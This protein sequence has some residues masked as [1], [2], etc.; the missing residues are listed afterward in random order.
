ME[1]G[2]EA[3]RWVVG[4][5]L[6]PASGGVLEAWAA[7]SELGPNIRDLRMELLYAQGM[8][9]NARSH[10]YGHGPEIKNPALGELLQELRDLAYRADDVMDELD[11]FRIQDEL[12]G[13][14]HAADE[15]AGGCLRNYA[16]NARHTARAI[17]SML[18]F[19]KCSRGSAGHDEPD[20]EDTRGRGIS[21]GV[22]PCLGPKT[23]VDDNEQEEDASLKVRC[24]AV[25]PCGRASST[26][27]P[28]N[29]QGDQ[30][31]VQSSDEGGNGC[32]GRLATGASDTINTVGKHLPCFSVSPVQNDANPNTASSGRRFLCCARPNKAPRREC[33]GQTPKLKFDRV[34]MS[35]TMKEIV[36]QLKP[37]CAKVSAILNLEFLAANS[38]TAQRMATSR[39]IT[40]SQSI[41]PELYGRKKETSNI[42]H[43]ITK[44]E[45]CDKDLTVLPIV[46]PGG[47]GK[48]TLMQY[49]YSDEKLQNHFEVKLW[50]CVSVNFNV[51]RLTQEVADKLPKDEKNSGDKKIEE[52]LK[53]KR[54]L[55]VLDDMW[56]CRDEDEWKKFLVP[57]TKG[58]KGSVILVTTR[59]PAIAQMVKTTDRWK[60][61]EGLDRESFE[62]LFIACAFGDNQSR[63][64]HR[65]LIET[66]DKILGKLKGSPLAAKTVGRLLRNHLDLGHWTR[67]L[68]SKEWELQH[69][70]HD[71]MPALKLS[72]DYLPFHLQQ[73]FTYCALFPEDYK[74]GA[75]ELIH[76]WIGL[77]VLHSRG[78]NKSIED[79][80]LRYLIELVNHG[81]FKKEE[82]EY[83]RTYYII[84]DL[85]HD[86][87]MKVSA[88]EC[89][90][91]C[92]SDNVRSLQIPQSIRHL[93]INMDESSVKDRK[94]FDICNICKEDFSVLGKKLKFEN[95]HSLMLFGEDQG[96]FVKTFRG[97][98][99]KA[100]AIR[101]IF[102][103]GGNYSVEDLLHNFSNLVH[104]RYLRIAGSQTPKDISR[105]YHLRVVDIKKCRSSYDLPRHMGNL[106]KLRHFLVPD[107]EMHAS[108]F[109]VGRLKSL[110]ELR[111]F[112]VRKESKGFELMQMGHLLELCGSLRIDSLEN[113]EGREEADE[114]KLMHKKHLHELMLNWNFERANE[115]P[116]R[117]EQV[118]QGLKPH[119]ILLKLSIRGHGGATCPSWLG[120]NLSVENLESLCLDG[121]AWKM[122]PPI[123]EFQL[124]NGAAEEISSNI[125]GQHFKNLKR[126]ELANLARLQRWVVGSSGQLL[127]H[128]EELIIRDCP[129]LVELP[130]SNSTCIEQEQK[131]T[132]PRLQKLAIYSCPKLVSLPPVP[133]TSSLRSVHIYRVGLD[134][135]S[136][137]Y[138]KDQREGKGPMLYIEGKGRAQD[139]TASFWTVLGFDKLTGLESLVISRNCPL[140]PLDVLQ[141]L[142]SSIKFLNLIECNM[143][144]GK[145]LGQMLS[146]MP[147]LSELYISG[148]EKIT[149]LGV[150]EQLEEGKEEIATDELLLL[151][152][153][154]QRLQILECPELSLRPD[155]G[156]LQGLAFLVSLC[157]HQCPKF[158][159]SYLP[160][161]SSSC[162][163]FP[164]SLQYLN[165]SRMETLAPLSNLASLTKLSIEGC[166]DFGGVDLG[167][168]LAN[169]CLRELSVY[170]TPNI[171]F[172]TEC[173]EEPL[174]LEMLQLQSLRTDDVA[175]VLA[176]PIC[177]LFSSSL[178]SLSI[179]MGDMERFT[180]EQDEALQ[181]LTSLKRLQLYCR[182]LQCLPAGLQKL[183]NLETLVIPGT[184]GI[185][186]SLHRGSL[187]DSLQELLITGGGFQSLPK[188]SL[189][190]SLRKLSIY[191]CSAIRSLPKES[192]PNSLQELEI[193]SCPAIRALPKGGLPS[194]LQILDVRD[195][196][197]EDLRRQCRK[198][199]GTVPV[200]RA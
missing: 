129:E 18:G 180:K 199:I 81:F 134:F 187:P 83:G 55:L 32:I 19:S 138:G 118:L 137:N 131:T 117:E 26:S 10:G 16:L 22:C 144:S 197:S 116:G 75:A 61:L 157:V 95:L 39:P 8:L 4:R 168:L 14:Y 98:F 107:D 40:T 143:L 105:F 166:G 97:L 20:E 122:F 59:F 15:H 128:L 123:G 172:S 161:P 183:A 46:G 106:L 69:G 185:I 153:Q 150:V 5:A 165:L 90:S 194:S 198:L 23:H 12:D 86:L 110:Q 80:G 53:S 191:N 170:E 47:I 6:V 92:S 119:S 155:S 49:I 133:W 77:D 196:N 79:I 76:L 163:P 182:K 192:L 193:D 82:D 42:I 71:I 162:F 28:T 65:E 195:G 37:L 63:N 3:A 108:I 38:S 160:W 103:S 115:D 27:S 145:E 188:D 177:R 156:G 141:K 11:Y 30:E 96:S 48:T 112:E 24:G 58:Q 50:V 1:V 130:F 67:V 9:N 29:Q 146:C 178:T 181:F 148:C 158:L 99:R 87:A 152:P 43:D 41:E 56:D 57:F 51:H 35:R 136:V 72:F 147:Q 2:I 34:E 31:V 111:R 169:G 135:E 36:E 184:P 140:L 54:F 109:E 127:S 66:G 74:F 125:P 89:L 45:Y 121:V 91:I 70:D 62:E 13:T 93:S 102:I 64:E 154:L 151:P 149:G 142:S 52:Q 104:L 186:H 85:L 171:F 164:T 100:K 101:V 124:V 33:V 174:E 159:A 132:F 113:V 21:C 190:N 88:D 73:C 60:D 167:H 126:I 68:E 78:E 176:A 7:S 120:V 179:L 173:S 200:V 17:A 25:W 175:S 94:T 84:H 44:G 114:A 189:P 139:M